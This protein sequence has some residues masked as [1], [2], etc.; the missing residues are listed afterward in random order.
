VNWR[1]KCCKCDNFLESRSVLF[2]W[3]ND[4]RAHMATLKSV[5]ASSWTR[6]LSGA[7]E[8]FV[9]KR[10]VRSVSSF[11]R[12]EFSKAT[13][14]FAHRIWRDSRDQPFAV[15]ANLPNSCRSLLV[16]VAS[17][18]K[19]NLSAP[20]QIP[21]AFRM[22]TTCLGAGHIL[23]PRATSLMPSQGQRMLA[24]STEGQQPAGIQGRFKMIVKE[25]GKV[26]VVE[27]CPIQFVSACF[28][29][30]FSSLLRPTHRS[31][32]YPTPLSGRRHL[33]QH[34]WL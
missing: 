24:T 1:E 16:C 17:G 30:A 31:L 29:G 26:L 20:S 5:A 27:S 10:A 8:K 11:S 15:T 25:Y 32:C 6:T 23:F 3:S 7:A 9:A 14:G 12:K 4:F 19:N 21:H 18:S 34:T 22:Q 13:G 33:L 28:L 2:D